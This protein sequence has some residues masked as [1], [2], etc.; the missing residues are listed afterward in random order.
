M[1]TEQQTRKQLIDAELKKAGWN[2]DDPG[3]VA[4]AFDQ[5]IAQHTNL[6]TRQL[7]FLR[8]LKEFIIEREKVEKRDLIQSPFTIIHPRGI[9]GVFR[10]SEIDEILQLT[11]QLAA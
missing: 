9:R 11:E 10:P 6:N 8:L 2:V 7:E 5:F 4:K 1:K 3:T